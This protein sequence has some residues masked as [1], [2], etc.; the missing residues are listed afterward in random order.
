[1]TSCVVCEV[2]RPA[3]KIFRSERPVRHRESAANV[4]FPVGSFV[5]LGCERDGLVAYDDDA[6][7]VAAGCA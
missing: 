3:S 2:S 1:V 5:C 6:L 4:W 7:P